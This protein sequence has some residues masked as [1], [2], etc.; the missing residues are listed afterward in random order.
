VRDHVV[1]SDVWPISQPW[2][3]RPW[4]WHVILANGAAA[5]G[6]AWT[7]DGAYARLGRAVQR[8]QKR[9]P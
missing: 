6:L 9:R 3:R 1:T 7:R 2:W 4:C 5:D 8:L